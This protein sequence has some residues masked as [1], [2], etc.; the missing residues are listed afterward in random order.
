MA[1]GY[2]TYEMTQSGRGDRVAYASVTLGGTGPAPAERARQI[3]RRRT[4][5]GAAVR[6]PRP[7]RAAARGD[8]P[9]LAVDV[10][11]HPRQDPEAL[12]ERERH[13]N[14]FPSMAGRC[15]PFVG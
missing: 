6:V 13:E 5:A 1:A 14:S 15:G 3:H 11:A 12:A 8:R 7:V 2:L 9:R 10:E 4:A